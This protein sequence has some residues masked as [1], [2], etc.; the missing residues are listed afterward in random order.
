MF[1][2]LAFFTFTVASSST[3]GPNTIMS[4]SNGSRK[5]FKG[6]LPFTLGIYAGFSLVMLLCTAFCSI[7]SAL[8]PKIKTPML[9]LGAVYM[10]YLAWKTFRSAGK[11]EEGQAR[12]GFLSGF[13]MQFIN[14][15]V[16]LYGI[17]AL[18]AYVLPVYQG[19]V[20]PLIGFSFLLSSIAF[21]FNLCWAGFGS[22]FQRL[23]SRHGK[24]I[25]TIMALLLVYCAASLLLS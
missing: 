6:A 4:L 15:K 22:V 14:P 16:Y 12:D 23:F 7:L 8:L 18:E 11:I 17:M 5:G 25:N 1:N 19:K 9:V 24:T 13:L 2:W 10:L 21:V 20:L 3:P